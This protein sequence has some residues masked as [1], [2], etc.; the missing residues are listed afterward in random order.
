MELGPAAAATVTAS[1]SA[2]E[3]AAAEVDEVLEAFLDFFFVEP[4]L[5][6][7]FRL[8]RRGAS[9]DG[10]CSEGKYDKLIL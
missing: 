10:I 6:E 9:G 3:A 8:F 4:T 1:S 2:E 5:E 7:L